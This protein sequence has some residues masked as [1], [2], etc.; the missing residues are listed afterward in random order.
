[1]KKTNKQRSETPASRAG[2]LAAVKR[3]K[4]SILVLSVAAVLFLAALFLI[5]SRD[6]LNGVGDLFSIYGE[7]LV[8][9]EKAKE[10]IE[11]L[12]KEIDKCISLLE[13]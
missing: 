4:A 8:E 2:I 3:G 10:K 12:I 1:M 13:N 9:F 11:R 7:E 6:M 5:Y